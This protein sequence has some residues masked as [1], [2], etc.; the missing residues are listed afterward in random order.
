MSAVLDRWLT[1]LYHTVGAALF[2]A[3]C[4]VGAYTAGDGP[5]PSRV[6][7]AELLRTT[8]TGLPADVPHGPAPLVDGLSAACTWVR[9]IVAHRTVTPCRVTCM[10]RSSLARPV[11]GLDASEA[12]RSGL[13]DGG[14]PPDLVDRDP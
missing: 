1:R 11:P 8:Q 5:R 2:L 12:S 4:A 3:L 9:G 6:R 7:S 14:G 10:R 13:R